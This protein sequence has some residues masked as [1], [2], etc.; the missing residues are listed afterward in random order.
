MLADLNPDILILL[1]T[2]E[3]SEKKLINIDEEY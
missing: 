2:G 3:R 1:E